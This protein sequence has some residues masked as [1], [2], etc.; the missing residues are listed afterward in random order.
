IKATFESLVDWRAHTNLLRCNPSFWKGKGRFDCVFIDTGSQ[1]YF[2][3]LLFV[4]TYQVK[5]S[6]DAV[7]P[8]GE[9]EITPAWKNDK[10]LGLHRLQETP[11]TKAIF[12]PAWSFIHGAYIF[13]E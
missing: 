11:L 6:E 4:F 5:A 3:K 2:A 12:V 8:S 7:I 10:D 1:P 9:A 13:P